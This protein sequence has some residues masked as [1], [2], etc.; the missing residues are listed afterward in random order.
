ML[1]REIV[2]LKLRKG[3]RLES[4]G[5]PFRQALEVAARL[6]ADGIEINA[7]TEIRPSELTRTGVR[8]IKKMLDDYKL[9]VA[10][11]N[12]P[13]RRGYSTELDLDQRLDATRA[14][15]SM[16]YDL[17]CTVVS[18]QIGRIPDSDSPEHTTLVQALEDIG[19]H[20][21][22]VGSFFAA[23]TGD[24]PCEKQ[25]ELLRVLGPGS[26]FVDFDPAELMLAGE[27]PADSIG[28]L[29]EYVMHFRARDAVRDLSRSENVVVQLGRGSVDLAMLLATLETHN[30]S[31]YLTVQRA[32]GTGNE[33]ILAEELEY[34]Q[35]V[36]G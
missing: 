18:N 9:K 23:R 14:A 8:Q 34:L 19:R 21:Q 32:P 30:Y 33:K 11:V 1:E 10:C 35:K 15:M 27:Y 16:A 13:T 20:G 4:L 25:L 28:Q 36:F 7:R 29:A 2:L 26:L 12:F 3:I 22:R 31:G 6:G 17:G 24:N 5:L